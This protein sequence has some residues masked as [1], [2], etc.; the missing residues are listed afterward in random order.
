V[1]AIITGRARRVL[2]LLSRCRA[3]K[4]QIEED[5]TYCPQIRGFPVIVFDLNIG[6][7]VDVRDDQ[8]R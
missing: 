4:S 1:V 3:R 8:T 2:S 7:S 5:P 6:S